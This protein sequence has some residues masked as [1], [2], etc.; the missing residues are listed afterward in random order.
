MMAG[1]RSTT[2][3]VERARAGRA[4]KCGG[5]ADTGTLDAVD[6]DRGD[7][8]QGET[9]RVC[10]HVRVS[11]ERCEY[12]RLQM[13]LEGLLAKVTPSHTPAR[14]SH[15]ALQ[16]A[17]GGRRLERTCEDRGCQQTRSE[18]VSASAHGPSTKPRYAWTTDV[19][20]VRQAAVQGSVRAC[21]TSIRRVQRAARLHDTHGRWM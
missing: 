13:F 4:C 6:L 1:E 2:D 19:M 10:R 16:L 20:H 14:W 21:V 5:A 15:P 7:V 11:D 3:T 17:K 18:R 9:A 12:A 8:V